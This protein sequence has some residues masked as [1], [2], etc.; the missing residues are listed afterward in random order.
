MHD[1][2]VYTRTYSGSYDTVRAI[3]SAGQELWC[4][5]GH[6]SVVTCIAVHDRVVY[7]GSNKIVLTKGST[8]EL[9]AEIEDAHLSSVIALAASDDR[10]GVDRGDGDVHKARNEVGS[11]GKHQPERCE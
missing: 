11:D 10:L 4:Y 8:G 7:S 3:D 9:V 2:V 6:S 5:E 1:R